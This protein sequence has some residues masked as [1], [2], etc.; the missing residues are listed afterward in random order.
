MENKKI[1]IH[2]HLGMGDHI[3]LNGLVRHL[4][5]NYDHIILL[6]KENNKPNVEF[7][8]R[9]LL[10]LKVV[11]IGVPLGI[12]EELNAAQKVCEKYPEHQYIKIG[13]E[14]HQA[15]VAQYPHMSCDQ[16]FYKQLDVPYK[17]RFTKFHFVRD[18]K[19]EE[20]AFKLV[21]PTNVPYI[22]I[23]DNPEVGAVINRDTQFKVIKN[24]IRINIA[25]FGKILENAKEVHLMESSIR[26]LIEDPRLSIK[27]KLFYHTLRGGYHAVN[28]KSTRLQWEV[29]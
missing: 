17:Y 29:I 2:H 20:E 15:L 24:D 10:R 14:S 4:Y 11:S 9:D 18:F 12:D 26:C 22:F 13:F 21:N 23:H 28:S 1:I 3:C 16:L 7:L 25:H 19:K 27:G 5:E 6:S 8:F